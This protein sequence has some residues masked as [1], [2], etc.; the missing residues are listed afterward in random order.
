LDEPNN[1][2]SPAHHVERPL[3]PLPDKIRT[4]TMKPG[5]VFT[6]STLG[7]SIRFNGYLG[8]AI[9]A[10]P[11]ACSVSI[12]NLES[13]PP[14]PLRHI[15]FAGGIVLNPGQ[16]KDSTSIP[17][18]V[19]LNRTPINLPPDPAGSG[20]P[21]PVPVEPPWVGHDNP[22]LVRV[23]NQSP[24]PVENVQVGVSA[25]QPAVITDRCSSGTV[26]PTLGTS[27]I[28]S[29]PA[30]SSALSSL[31]WTPG[32][33]AGSVS[34]DVTA[35]GP[36]NQISTSSRFAF[37]F[38]HPGKQ[39][40]KERGIRTLLKLSLDSGCPASESFSI[41]PAVQLPGWQV[42]VSPSSVSLD[43]GQ[44]ETIKIRVIPPPSAE[45]GD[46]AEIPI[47]VRKYQAMLTLE[48]DATDNP[49]NLFMQPGVHLNPVG[50][51]TILARV[52]GGPGSIAL[53]A[54]RTGLVNSPLSVSGSISPSVPNSPISI[55]Y[56]PPSGHTIAH[57]VQ[58]DTSGG[59]SDNITPDQAGPWKVQS[60]WPGDNAHDPVES[61]QSTV[62]EKCNNRDNGKDKDHLKPD[63]KVKDKGK[64]S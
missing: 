23:N 1:L 12:A 19:G 11:G 61:L 58:T 53:T 45:V 43:P 26:S 35:T 55:E 16:L 2:K 36:G 50:A 21:L 56:R 31:D 37:Q 27:T 33:D 7:L 17:L 42:L 15:R 6:D 3:L 59:Y 24:G 51:F 47:L 8:G 62:V 20:V 38:H 13:L 44:D 48:P 5:D 32:P 39:D 14:P 22:V 40:K 29:I 18:D 30:A 25:S 46:H 52:T 64:G 63:C 49:P 4:A 9:G 60:R 34:F 10:G 28:P 57:I 54:P 41:L